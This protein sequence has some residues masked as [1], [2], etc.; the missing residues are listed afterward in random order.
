[1]VGLKGRKQ[2]K[3]EG[4]QRWGEGEEVLDAGG[5]RIMV[6][7]DWI[8]KTAAKELRCGDGCCESGGFGCE[9]LSIGERWWEEFVPAWMMG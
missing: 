1:M 3:L 6:M 5:K 7:K 8:G 2:T 4:R 9:F